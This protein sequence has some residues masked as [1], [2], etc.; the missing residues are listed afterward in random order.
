MEGLS[1]KQREHLKL[2]T[3]YYG[4]TLADYLNCMST[5]KSPEIE[6]KGY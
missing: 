6:Y 5:R 3:N 1:R 2:L 4:M